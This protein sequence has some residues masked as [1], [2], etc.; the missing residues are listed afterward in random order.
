MV[1]YD[2]FYEKTR[3]AMLAVTGFMALPNDAVP[4]ASMGWCC[5]RRADRELGRLEGLKRK[6]S[7]GVLQP[8]TKTTT[9][10][11]ED[12]LRDVATQPRTG[13]PSAPL[14][15]TRILCLSQHW[16]RLLQACQ[17]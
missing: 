1:D 6:R 16:V 5:T 14:R 4:V 15:R 8:S 2:D 12:A 13:T 7:N 10:D 9:I 17:E 3:G 11:N